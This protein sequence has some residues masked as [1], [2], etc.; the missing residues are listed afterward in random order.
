M[1]TIKAREGDVIQSVDDVFFDVKGLVHPPRRVI[2]FIRFFPHGSGNRSL[3][4]T[5]YSKVYSLDKRFSLLEERFPQYIFYD[6][7]FDETLCGVPINRVKRIFRPVEGLARLRRKKVL[8][9][10]ESKAVEFAETV[11]EAAGVRWRHIGISG[12]LLI[13]LHRVSSDIDIVVY[14]SQSCLKVYEALKALMA[15]VH[16]PVKPYSIE[17]LRKLYRFRS[18]DTRVGFEAFVRTEKRKFLQGIFRGTDFFIRFVKNW[19]EVDTRYGAVRYK[20][21]G[22]ATVRARIVDDSEALFTPCTYKINRVETLEG[23]R[24]KPLLEI[25]SFRGRFC[26]QARK[27]ETVVAKG[28]VERVTTSE[29]EYFRLLLGGTP[30]SYMILS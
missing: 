6:P 11:K 5:R 26:E 1:K 22:Y 13:G 25:V 28:K 23:K 7:I 16:A 9:K 29:K 27:G 15:D 10:L 4:E 21:V 14:G 30:D 17:G 3:G 18:K 19:H 20:K 12:S 2:A 24:V 8:D